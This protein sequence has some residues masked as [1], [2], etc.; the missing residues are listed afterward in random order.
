MRALAI[1]PQ[2]GVISAAAYWVSGMG[3]FAAGALM[4]GLIGVGPHSSSSAG[5]STRASAQ[6]GTSQPA[7]AE[8]SST[9]AQAS[10]TPQAPDDP[11]AWAP[12]P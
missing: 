1:R 11:G 4:V 8:V 10:K 12:G 2:S 5:Q 6:E 3:G 9:S 7:A